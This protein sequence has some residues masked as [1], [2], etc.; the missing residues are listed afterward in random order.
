MANGQGR[1]RNE[2]QGFCP[3]GG[4][5]AWGDC[6]GCFGGHDD[7]VPGSGPAGGRGSA[8]D[9][10]GSACCGPRRFHGAVRVSAL[11]PTHGHGNVASPTTRRAPATWPTK[12]TAV[13][14]RIT[15]RLGAN[16]AAIYNRNTPGQETSVDLP[17]GR[18]AKCWDY[19]AANPANAERIHIGTVRTLPEGANPNTLKR[20]GGRRAWRM[21]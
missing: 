11:L 21:R 17:S 19:S 20:T 16:P 13:G 8:R 1:F 2:R 5:C 14:A 10:A 4:T 18:F 15:G 6:V 7:A 3:R 9:R 12:G